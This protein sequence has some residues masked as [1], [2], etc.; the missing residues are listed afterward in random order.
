MTTP[1]LTAC[2]IDDDR[3]MGAFAKMTFSGYKTAQAMKKLM[4][5]LATAKI[6]GACYWTAE[7]ICSGHYANLWDTIFLFYGKHVHVANPKLA[8]YLEGKLSRFKENMNNAAGAQEQLDFRNDPNFRHMFCEIVTV[9][10]LS[11]KKFILQYS[12]VPDED[13]DLIVLKNN[14]IAPDFT[15]GESIIQPDDPKELLVTVNELQYSLSRE[16][17]NTMRAYYWV[18]WLL[19]YAKLCKKRKQTCFI[20]RREHGSVDVKYQRNIVW[21]IW[22]AILREAHARRGTVVAKVA[23]ALFQ[24]F[25]LR[26]TEA[27]NTRRKSLIYFAVTLLTNCAQGAVEE[28]PMVQDKGRVDCA[29]AQINTVFAQVRNTTVSPQETPQETPQPITASPPDAPRTNTSA[30]EDKMKIITIFEKTYGVRRRP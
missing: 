26:Y 4:E 18:E 9:L 19:D 29:M 1:V 15:R 7:L 12:R 16:V 8:I 10:C 5:S 27:H 21:L 30:S 17:V 11:D 23:D 3:P 25:T 24:M 14:L 28:T 2:H 22:D 20:Q 6:E 13:F